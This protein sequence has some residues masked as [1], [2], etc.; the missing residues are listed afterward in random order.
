MRVRGTSAG[1]AFP[2]PPTER[3]RK[4]PSVSED[5]RNIESDSNI[6]KDYFPH[7]CTGAAIHVFLRRASNKTWMPGT[8]PGM[9]CGEAERQERYDPFDIVVVPFRLSAN[10]VRLKQLLASSNRN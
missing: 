8:R 1:A 6:V 7:R 3:L 9:P 2:A 5:G 10:L 4:A